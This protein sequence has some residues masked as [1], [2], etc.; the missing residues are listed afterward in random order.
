M[1]GRICTRIVRNCSGK[2]VKSVSELIEKINKGEKNGTN[3]Y[4]HILMNSFGTII[5]SESCSVVYAFL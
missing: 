4:I 3:K 2:I 1:Y 5:E